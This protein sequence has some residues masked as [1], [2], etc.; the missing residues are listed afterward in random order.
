MATDPATGADRACVLIAD[1]DPD[2]LALLALL[3]ERDGYRVVRATDGLEAL[4]LARESMPDL[5]VLDVSM[6]GAD[7]YTVCRELLALQLVEIGNAFG[8][9]DHSTVIHSLERV[10]ED[11]AAEADF[12]ERVLRVRG[13]L[14]T[15][16]T[17]GQLGT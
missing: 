2:I 16:R 3:L 17:T 8:G 4:R 1:D 11:M 13:M 10:A 14:E 7:G 15:L 9:R 5:C 12:S 6:P